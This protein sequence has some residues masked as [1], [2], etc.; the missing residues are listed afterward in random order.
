MNISSITG[1]GQMGSGVPEVILESHTQRATLPP[2][3][4]PPKTW[5]QEVVEMAARAAITGTRQILQEA[6]AEDSAKP[7]GERFRAS[8]ALVLSIIANLGLIAAVV[9]HSLGSTQ[10]EDAQAKANEALTKELAAANEALR[11]Q[12][13]AD[14][15]FRKELA[16]QRQELAAQ[17]RAMY[18]LIDVLAEA[19]PKARNVERDLQ[20]R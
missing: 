15:E 3:T 13:Q 2:D 12:A 1:H 17:R 9:G 6:I 5:Q 10:Y 4:G 7:S 8:L 16:A 11:K 14:E 18:G 20:Q 19:N